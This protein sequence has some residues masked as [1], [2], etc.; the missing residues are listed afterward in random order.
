MSDVSVRVVLELNFSIIRCDV[1]VRVVRS[2]QILRV[3]I[4]VGLK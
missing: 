4:P 3:F 1:S 2:V